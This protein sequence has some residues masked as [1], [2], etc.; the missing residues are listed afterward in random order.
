MTA[1][2]IQYD[3]T[4]RGEASP[5]QQMRVV[6]GAFV[7]LTVGAA[8]VTAFTQGLFLGPVSAE[9]H[10]SKSQFFAGFAVAGI[11]DAAVMPLFAALADRIGIRRVLLGGIVAYSL[12][13][14]SLGTLTGSFLQFMLL[15]ALVGIMQTAQT[16]LLYAKAISQTVVLRRR[17]LALAVAFTGASVG[18]ALIPLVVTYLIRAV[19]WRGAYFSL[20]AIV[21]IVALPAVFFLVHPARDAGAGGDRGERIA[22]APAGLTFGQALR[23]PLFWML[24]AAITLEVIA[25][26]GVFLNLPPIL[27]KHGFSALQIGGAISLMGLMQVVGRLLLG[28]SL[29]RSR[30]VRIAIAFFACGAGGMLLMANATS[31]AQALT[32]AILSGIAIGSEMEM[33]AYFTSRLFGMRDYGRIFGVV[34]ACFTIG[35]ALAPLLVGLAAEARGYPFAIGLAVCAIVVGIMLLIAIGPYRFD[36]SQEAA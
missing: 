24:A 33:A 28:L 26:H 18:G 32:G 36:A 11:V 13:L 7:A 6:G 15:S 23:A 21:S 14:A 20:G 16:P 35:V 10:W 4:L 22:Q 31:A 9:L 5:R 2:A 8:S 25:V 30:S 17:G 34:L 1:Q 27:A 3:G 12:A 19:G 29:D